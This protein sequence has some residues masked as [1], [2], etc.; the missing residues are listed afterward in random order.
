[1]MEVIWA[2]LVLVAAPTFILQCLFYARLRQHHADV[3]ERLGKPGAL[4][5][6]WLV[7]VFL[8][9]GEYRSLTNKSAARLAGWYRLGLIAFMLAFVPA[10]VVF[11][12]AIWHQLRLH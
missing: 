9:R 12:V 3:W 1:M 2:L 6:G 4:R 10:F 8:W 11:T 7:V 5:G